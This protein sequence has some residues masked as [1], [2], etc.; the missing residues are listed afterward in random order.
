MCQDSCYAICQNRVLNTLFVDFC[1]VPRCVCVC[2]Y[3]TSGRQRHVAPALGEPI[4]WTGETWSTLAGGSRL[5]ST[6]LILCTF[7]YKFISKLYYL[8]E[9]ASNSPPPYKG[10]HYK[11]HS[12]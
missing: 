3:L 10:A 8:N 11:K 5:A 9:I 2:M 12:P 1:S 4:P 6:A 7:A